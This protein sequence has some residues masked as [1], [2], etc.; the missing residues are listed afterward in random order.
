MFV[1]LHCVLHTP[2]LVSELDEFVLRHHSSELSRSSGNRRKSL[3]SRHESN[4]L[5][6][7]F[8]LRTHYP[9]GRTWANIL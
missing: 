3:S 7:V 9:S 8:I 1:S 2:H 5:L 6:A 4:R